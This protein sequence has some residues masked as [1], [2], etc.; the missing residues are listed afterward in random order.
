MCHKSD[1][2]VA[3]LRFQPHNL[4]HS[5]ASSCGITMQC[6]QVC[7][8]IPA[9]LVAS[10]FLCN[11]R[12]PRVSERIKFSRRSCTKCSAGWCRVGRA[13]LCACQK[14]RCGR[15]SMPTDGQ[16]TARDPTQPTAHSPA[17][18]RDAAGATIC[19]ASAAPAQRGGGRR[20]IWLWACGAS[21]HAI[22]RR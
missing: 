21:A 20:L 16:C 6:P 5:L 2:D 13:V 9:R 3:S 7:A 4:A 12:Q 14:N 18:N 11:T 19:A 22:S 15:V 8:S 1:A 10:F 17:C